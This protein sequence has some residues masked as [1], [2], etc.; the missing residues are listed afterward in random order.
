M[1]RFLPAF[2]LPLSACGQDQLPDVS[3]M[4]VDQVYQTLCSSCHGVQFEG[5]LGGSLVD[6]VWKHGGTDEDLAKAIAKGFPDLGMVGYEETLTE[7]QIRSLV[8]FMRE[9]EAE[10][11]AKGMTFPSPEIGKVTKTDRA[12]YK[13]EL[14]AKN[15]KEPWAIAFLPDGSRLVTEKR[16]TLRVISKDDKLESKPIKNTPTVV[17]HAQ[18][19]LMEV[20]LHPDFEENGWIYLGISDPHPDDLK[21]KR[22]RTNTAVY[23][24]RIK[25]HEWV[26]SELIWKGPIEDYTTARTH[27][28]TRFIFKDGYLYFPVG[29]RGENMNSQKLTNSFGKT[30]RLHDDGRIPKDNPTFGGEEHLPGMWT[31]GHRN[32]QGFALHPETKEIWSTEH[33]PRGGDELNLIKPDLNY[34]WPIV[35]YGMNYNGTPIT[36]L[37]EKEGITN[38]VTYWVPSIAVCGLDFY[39]GDQFPGWENDLLVGGLRSQ[40]VERI[41]L[42]DGKVVEQEV[43]VKDKG[44]VR[45]VA[46]GLD[47]FVYILLNKPGQ[48]IRLVPA[49]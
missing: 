40:V 42:K 26:D 41:R 30:F 9:K 27:F 47:G 36:E 44:R 28:G 14:V 18:G 10:T 37:T 45:D 16:G 12:S 15:L 49:N 2:L 32:P 21:K 8:I 1:K 17:H 20:A 5:G 31:M 11:Q 39:E 13:T 25:D 6:G 38:P 23:R 22:K 19:G 34:G 4:K 29:E 3:K 35:T 46:T 33:G 24:G 7:K 48:I 43:I